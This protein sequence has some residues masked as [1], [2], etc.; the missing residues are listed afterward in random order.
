MHRVVDQFNK[1]NKKPYKIQ[2]SAGY[3]VYDG[4]GNATLDTLIS[5]ADRKMYEIK[6]A[7]KIREKIC[8]KS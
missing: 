1:E 5:D 6:N 2:L 7:K 4:N 8:F 3:T